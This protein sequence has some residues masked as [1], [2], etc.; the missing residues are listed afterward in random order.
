MKI[1]FHL[2]VAQ[3]FSWTRKEALRLGCEAVQVF[4]KNPRSWTTKNLS[5]K[6]L[7]EFQRLSSDVEVFGHLSYLPNLAKI[8]LDDRNLNGVMH[9]ADL[10]SQLGI[11]S[12]VV[13]C[14]SRSDTGTGIAMTAQ[15]VN[16]ILDGHDIRILL[17]NSSGQGSSIGK[18]VE[19]LAG[20]FEGVERKEN[21]GICI[22]TAHL[23][24]GGCDIRRRNLWRGFQREIERLLGRRRIG[25]FHLNDSKTDLGSRVDR[26]WHIGKGKIGTSP[27]KSILNDLKFVDL[28]GV[29]ETPK[30]DSMDEE[31]MK[32]M[33]SLLSPL[34][35]CP[36]P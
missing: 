33:K 20:I 2:S 36:F 9:E 22:D 5:D 10:C 34:V 30:E 26:H 14:G 7:E 6:D 35:S 17:E 24:E 27:F 18:N 4:V 11:R 19:E 16:R 15:A 1:G 25:L 13:H 3:G 31:N 12:L 8:D 32:T 29:M 21:V 28:C 23:F